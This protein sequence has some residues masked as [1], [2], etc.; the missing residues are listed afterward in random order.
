MELEHTLNLVLSKEKD[1]NMI[2]KGINLV[3]NNYDLDLILKK[4]EDIYKGILQENYGNK[5]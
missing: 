4:I 1:I 5:N 2:Q 3:E